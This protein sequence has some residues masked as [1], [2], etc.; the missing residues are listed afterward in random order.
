MTRKINVYK[1]AVGD[2]KNMAALR[3]TNIWSF[4]HGKFPYNLL[5]KTGTPGDRVIFTH[6][7][8]IVGVGEICSLPTNSVMTV[9]P[10]NK[11][12]TDSFSVDL[13]KWGVITPKERKEKNIKLRPGAVSFGDHRTFRFAKKNLQYSR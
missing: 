3:D 4:P 7:G 9:F 1:F 8:S 13:E 5:N 11:A 12:Y 10:D 6:Q 2:V